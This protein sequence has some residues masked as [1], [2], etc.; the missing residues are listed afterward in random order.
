MKASAGHCFSL[1]TTKVG[2]PFAGSAETG[3]RFDQAAAA[4]LTAGMER[5]IYLAG[6]LALCRDWSV[7]AELERELMTRLASRAT[8]EQW[9]LDRRGR[10]RNLCGLAIVE[11]IDPSLR[12]LTGEPT[13]VQTARKSWTEI[14]D[15]AW[16]RT[17]SSRYSVA[18][19]TLGQWVEIA[20]AHVKSRQ[21]EPVDLAQ[22]R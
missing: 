7:A 16:S 3:D 22:G 4:A 12:V 9:K 15:S 17:W 2:N 20:E 8:Y 6:R 21:R 5:R 1:L 19:D 13:L 11:T 14:S 18:R 10:L